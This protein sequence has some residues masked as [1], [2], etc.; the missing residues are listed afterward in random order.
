MHVTINGI[1]LYA[2]VGSYLRKS[3]N[4]NRV[5]NTAQSSQYTSPVFTNNKGVINY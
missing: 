5:S 1:Y 3:R 4:N 2:Q